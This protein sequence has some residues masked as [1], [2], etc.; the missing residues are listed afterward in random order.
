MLPNLAPAPEVKSCQKINPD[1]DLFIGKFGSP[2]E[3][4]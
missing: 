4:F 3:M 2:S 1:Y